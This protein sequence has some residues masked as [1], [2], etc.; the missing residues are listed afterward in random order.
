MADR[1]R[2]LIDLVLGSIDEPGA[3]VR[4]TDGTAV[5][6]TRATNL[7]RGASGSSTVLTELQPGDELVVVLESLDAAMPSADAVSALPRQDLAPQPVEA[8][9][10]MLFRPPR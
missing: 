5:R 7:H 2:E 4:L 3:I 8:T 1:L 9:E 6:V 10:V